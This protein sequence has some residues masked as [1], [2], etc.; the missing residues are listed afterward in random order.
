M[1]KYF[2]IIQKKDND[3]NYCTYNYGQFVMIG[4]T[5]NMNTTMFR[6]NDYIDKKYIEKICADKKYNANVDYHRIKKADD[7]FRAGTYFTLSL[8]KKYLEESEYDSF[9]NDNPIIFKLMFDSLKEENNSLKEEN[10]SLKEENNS[11]KEK[12]KKYSK[13]K[14]SKLFNFLN[15]K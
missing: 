14:Y 1:S 2:T 11:L 13:N 7:P 9:K 5:P 8:I 3:I 4:Y 6:V 12:L 10:D 15:N